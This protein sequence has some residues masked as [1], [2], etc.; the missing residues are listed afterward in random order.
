MKGSIRM[1]RLFRIG[2]FVFRL[3]APQELEPPLN[4]MRFACE[5]GE[6]QYT[7][8]IALS[9]GFPRPEGKLIAARAD[10]A[11]LDRE[12]LETRYI[13]VKGSMGAYACYMETDSAHAR[14]CLARAA[15]ESLRI[16]PM[17]LSVLAME[18]RLL[19]R[20][21]LVLHCAYMRHRGEAILFSAPSETGKTTQATLWEKHRASRVINGDRSLL[22]SVYG[23]WTARGWPVCGSSQVC[24]NEDTPIRAI[25]MLSQGKQDEVKRLTPTQAFAQIYSQI[26]INSWDRAAQQQAM[27]L[28]EQLVMQIPVYHLSCTISENAVLCLEDALYGETRG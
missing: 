18:K 27:E 22:Q 1:N 8:E 15:L 2:D 14:V 9:D 23:R 26:T 17:F 7:Y 28:I 20:R 3:I 21:G 6:A 5:E 11:V 16:D 24:Q 4:F 19:E 12:G 13:G 25:V 10:I